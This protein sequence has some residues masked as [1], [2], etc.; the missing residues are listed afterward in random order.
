MSS[1]RTRGI[2]F[3]GDYLILGRIAS[4]GMGDVYFAHQEKLNRT[5]A[6]KLMRSGPQATPRER[7]RFQ[8]EA[9]AVA[10]LDHKGIVRIIEIG[11]HEGQWFLSM[12]LH[13]GGSLADQ[14]ADGRWRLSRS[15]ARTQQRKIAE[16]MREVARA[17]SHAHQRGVLHRDIKPANILLDGDGQPHVTDFGL[18]KL[19]DGDAVSQSANIAGTPSY[20]APEQASVGITELT[21]AA[22]IYSLGAVLYELLAGRPP[23]VG[24]STVEILRQLTD[25][26]PIAPSRQTPRHNSDSKA[27][28]SGAGA[29][30]SN[31][32]DRDL[33]SICLRC[34]EK[35]P[36]GRYPNAD[37]LA[38]DL[39]HWLR[40]EPVQARPP[41]PI[42]R[43]W[44]W[45]RRRPALAALIAV[46]AFSVSAF[47]VFQNWQARKNARLLKE[48]LEA[49]ANEHKL[50]G[51]SLKAEHISQFL[52]YV[53]E[54]TG[55]TVARG[56]DTKLLRDILGRTAKRLDND[57]K[58]HPEVVADLRTTLGLVYYDIGDYP[59]AVESL[60]QALPVQRER[61]GTNHL[62]VA[63]TL[64]AL[65]LALHKMR[66]LAAA[67]PRY[68]E[69]LQIRRNQLGPEH[70][71]IAECLVNV[72]MLQ[73]EQ[74]D[75]RTAES[76][77][78]SALVMQRHVLDP[79]DAL[80]AASLDNLGGIRSRQGDYGEAASLHRQA[81]EICR[82][83]P[84]ESD[85]PFVATVLNNLA[86]ALQRQ[87][88]RAEAVS[89]YEEA[90][91]LRKKLHGPRHPQVAVVRDNLAFV[92]RRLGRSPEAE[93]LYREAYTLACEPA[94]E[95]AASTEAAGAAAPLI[96]VLLEQ[97]KY[98]E[99]EK[100][101]ANAQAVL[102]K[103]RPGHWRAYDLQFLHGNALL[104]L[105][106]FTAAEPLLQAAYT[107]AIVQAARIP[108]SGWTRFRDTLARVAQLW[109]P[110]TH[111]AQAAIWK[112]RLQGFDKARET[113][114]AR[115]SAPV[116]TP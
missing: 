14:L 33:E 80:I 46:S 108:D 47:A 26:E 21:T 40:G 84:N 34:L 100:L 60:E 92:L 63:E 9:E 45:T 94:P 55:P 102:E 49:R 31:I 42:L 15:N 70:R 83:K 25:Q 24:R 54:G 71:D 75:L 106:Q 74:G 77:L 107:N 79:A 112:E 93:K 95:G 28:P 103:T 104:G 36:V 68:Q 99:A 78:Q 52:R 22:D 58:E 57:L 116:Q 48:I 114:R 4:G 96:E 8:L 56:A 12:E 69:A 39:D 44:K 27:D 2:R 72:A 6:L 7:H 64:N 98:A 38:E 5:V 23:F 65:G 59:A 11:E 1:H 41:G 113:A 73:S 110:T 43:L 111:S 17:I 105:A 10:R 16:L 101:A 29:G 30:R 82:S 97:S 37:A 86:V 20:M 91:A 81:L 35:N 115:A 62:T 76:A 85:H 32:I 90:Y 18:A 3:F 67:L 13:E 53:L 51:E 109:P 87:G 50:R 61:L 19:F 89:Y 88:K 66:K